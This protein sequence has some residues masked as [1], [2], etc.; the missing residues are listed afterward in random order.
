MLSTSPR[1]VLARPATALRVLSVLTVLSL[2][3]Q[4]VTA[5]QLLPD[6]GPAGLHAGG[7]VALHVLSGL[8][9]GAAVLAWRRGAP[10]WPAVVVGLVFVLSFV[11]AALGGFDTLW[12]HVPGA[13]V[14]TIGAVAVATW[15][16]TRAGRYA[17]TEDR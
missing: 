16:L 6:G 13:F 7:A 2:A 12:V 4:F 10:L 11:Q 5:G 14:L 8:T 17:A 15:S 9:A 3:W 1:S